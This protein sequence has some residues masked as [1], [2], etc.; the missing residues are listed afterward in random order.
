MS[1]DGDTSTNDTVLVLAS[2]RANNSSLGAGALHKFSDALTEILEEL[3][4]KIVLDGEG[5]E[6]LVRINVRGAGSEPAALAVAKTIAGSQ[7]VKTAI[8]GQDPNWGRII[9][10]AG[11]AG[12]RFNPDK[13]KITI[14]DIVV[15]QRGLP[16]M[17]EQVEKRVAAVMKGKS[18]TIDL[19]LAAGKARGHYWTCDL[20]HTYVSINA[21]YRS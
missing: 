10:A 16:V 17:N 2:A 14:G 15:F 13:T 5:A 19:D 11:R 18:Y 3:G 7:L 12:V 20:G 9:A 8:Y 1:V 6:H 4:K 21:D